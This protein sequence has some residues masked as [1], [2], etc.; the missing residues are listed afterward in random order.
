MLIG[1]KVKP[2]FEAKTV[3]E[4]NVSRIGQ[5]RTFV[6]F[7][8]SINTKHKSADYSKSSTPKTTD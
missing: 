3:F 7:T 4:C 2:V 5:Y 8:D 6:T 1:E